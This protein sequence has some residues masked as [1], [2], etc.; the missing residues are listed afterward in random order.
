MKTAK[1]IFSELMRQSQFVPLVRYK[2]YGK[3]LALL[4]QRFRK[5]IAFVT[6]KNDILLIALSHPGY[7]MELDYNK[8]LLKSI[9]MELSKHDNE[10]SFPK[11]KQ[12]EFFISKHYLP[13]IDDI[14]DT[15]P[16]Y[17]EKA[18]GNFEFD[19]LDEDLKNLFSRIVQDI[20]CNQ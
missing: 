18:Q 6:I 13:K 7:K 1:N 11:I 3:F 8:D 9:L 15:V 4:P 19:Y 5:A 16:H 2:C 14:L 12:I 20:K 17:G 10:C